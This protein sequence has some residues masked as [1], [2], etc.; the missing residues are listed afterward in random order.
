MYEQIDKKLR[1]AQQRVARKKKL[2]AIITQLKIDLRNAQ[3]DAGKL[4]ES[5]EK[6]KLDVEELRRLSFKKVVYAVFS[7][8]VEH[9]AEEKEEAAR[10][11]FHY[12]V[13]QQA[14]ED[15]QA[16][17]A[18][19]EQERETY[20][21][22][23]A[24]YG[25]LLEEKKAMLAVYSPDAAQSVIDKSTQIHKQV[26]QVVDIDEAIAAGEEV[27][28]WLKSALGCLHKAERWSIFERKNSYFVRSIKEAYEED[29]QNVIAECRLL[30]QTFGEALADIGVG[31]DIQIYPV[32]FELDGFGRGY[33]FIRA[34]REKIDTAIKR[35]LSARTD[36]HGILKRL[37]TLK[38]KLSK[39]IKAGQADIARLIRE[40]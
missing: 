35:V 3:Y 15:I 13:A 34:E 37:R 19:Y 5:L 8:L 23:Q 40:A 29:A 22:S 18:Q 21:D 11:Q 9:T 25:R 14:V 6:E 17:L 33:R 10:A 28:P 20:A 38:W 32:F 30:L 12:N 4:R 7:T 16:K 24:E 39:K 31:G 27:L 2:D 36:V 1:A 26:N